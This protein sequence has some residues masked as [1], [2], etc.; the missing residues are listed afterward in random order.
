MHRENILDFPRPDDGHREAARDA[1]RVALSDALRALEDPTEVQATAVR[2]LGKWI[3]ANRAYYVEVEPDEEHVVC[4][5]DY[6][7]GVPSVVGRYRL[8]DFSPF[9]LAEYRAGRTLAFANTGDDPRVPPDLRAAWAGIQIIAHVAVPLVKSGRFVAAMAVDHATP[10]TWTADEMVLIEETAERTWAAVERARADALVRRSHDTFLAL[11]ERNPLGMFLVDSKFCLAQVSAGSRKAFK[12]IQPLTGRDLAEVLRIVWPEPFASEVIERFRHT[13]ATGTPYHS[14]DTTEVRGN[15]AVVESYDWQIQ[16]VTMPDGQFGVVC[17]FYDTT[18]QVQ[19]AQ[20]ARFL[21]ELTERIRVREDSAGLLEEAV[22]RLGEY[23]RADRCFFAE[24]DQAANRWRVPNDYHAGVVSLAGEYRLS[25]FPESHSSEL[26]QGRVL[27]VHDVQA[28]MTAATRDATYGSLASRAFI[29]VPMRRDGVWVSTLNVAA[30]VP[31][32]WQPREVRL[33]EVV[34]ERLWNAVERLRGESARRVS[35]ERYRGIVSQTVAGIAEVDLTG[36]FL[37]VNDRYCQIIGYSRAQLLERGMQDVTHPDD[38]P[39]NLELLK[40]LIAE[41]T[42]FEVEKRYVRPDGSSVWV[43]NSVSLIRDAAG[44][45]QSVIAVTIDI[46]ERR[47]VE[48]ALIEAAQRKDQFL[49][50]LA[51]E[52]RNPLAPIRNAAQVLKVVGGGDSKHEWAREVIE[53]QVQHLTRLVDDL[54]DVSRI[55]SGKVVL[56]RESIDVATI[57]NRAIETTRPLIDGRHHALAVTLPSAPLRVEGDL[58]RLVQV[59]ANLLNNAAKYTDEGGRL[60]LS[61]T[62]EQDD[63]VITVSDNG[64]GVSADLLPHIFDLFTQA[65]RSLDRSQGG[66]GVG[67]TLVRQLVEMHGGSVEARSAGPR[68]GSEFIVRLPVSHGQVGR[69]A[70]ARAE[71][72]DSV[73]PQSMRVLV[74]EDNL[75][76]A[77]MLSFMLSLAGHE[78]RIARDGAGALQAAGEFQP[79]VILCDIGLPGLDGYE[80]AKRL[81]AQPAFNGARLIAIS[82]YGQ[83]EDRRLSRDAGFDYHLTKPVEPGALIAM[84]AG[85]GAGNGSAPG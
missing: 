33:V 77:E 75:D 18:Q 9:I 71:A 51:H 6:T 63:V 31:R 82:G 74:V 66:L 59:V 35:E 53:R 69:Q 1:Y 12:G 61:V 22:A 70:A 42:P 5:S 84:L 27:V 40:R 28:D 23:L 34:A 26:R 11:I 57:V 47:K 19:E 65:D 38:L 4:A 54:L 58:T 3:G 79:H 45:P 21:A 68:C 64:V 7:D 17:Y 55:T 85:L 78:T 2:A 30:S 76:S 72:P 60:A 44:T 37:T 83:E 10:R 13:L 16:R 48:A 52:L 20:D 15:V 39:G 24:V 80:V 67:L 62:R 43:H 36:R 25:Q 14:P 41:G 56:R 29:A 49:A 46:T 73:H 32:E 8:A 81:R 50:M